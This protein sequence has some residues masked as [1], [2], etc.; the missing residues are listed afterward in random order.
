MPNLPVPLEKALDRARNELAHRSYIRGIEMLSALGRRMPAADPNRWGI[1]V[2]RDLPYID[3]GHPAHRLDLWMPRV[4]QGPLPVVLYIHGG[5]FHY[6]SKDT[7]WLMALAFARRGYMVLNL[8]YRL[9]P[10]HVFPA[11]LE[12]VA[13]A[14]LWAQRWVGNYGGDPSR[15]AVAGESAGANLALALTLA[16]NFDRPEPFA[17]ELADAGFRPRACLPACGILQV[18][19]VARFWEGR[20]LPSWVRQQLLEIEHGY[21]GRGQ[22]SDTSLADPLLLLERGDVP[23]EPLPPTMAFAGTRD[24]IWDDT[25]R[26]ERALQAR[27]VEVDA[28]IYEREIHAFHAQWYRPAA[29]DAWNA[30]FAF[31][32]RHL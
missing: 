14:A 6:L 17:R 31:L 29:R 27:G 20:S 7:H 11:A 8:N 1:R 25:A 30:Q 24:P 16:A 26:L 18:S 22:H 28:R 10:R 5:A 2:L 12:D 32:Q 13:R 23:R 15:I 21:L 4:R 3:D 9:A 19:D